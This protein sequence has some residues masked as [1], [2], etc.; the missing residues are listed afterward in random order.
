MKKTVI[1]LLAILVI[2]LTGC[3]QNASEDNRQTPDSEITPSDSL[4]FQ[5]FGPSMTP[6]ISDGEIINLEKTNDFQRGDIVVYTNPYDENQRHVNRIIGLPDE[7]IKLEEGNVVVINNKNSDGFELEEDYLNVKSKGSTYPSIG[8]GAISEFELPNNG[9]LVLG[10]N[11]N[12]STDS[13]SC[14]R[15]AFNGACNNENAQFYIT[16]DN[17]IGKVADIEKFESDIKTPPNLSGIENFGI[18]KDVVNPQIQT[19]LKDILENDSEYELLANYMAENYDYNISNA[20]FITNYIDTS[21]YT[22]ISSGPLYK[23]GSDNKEFAIFVALFPVDDSLK[24]DEEEQN[25]YYIEE[26]TEKSMTMIYVENGEI[27]EFAMKD[28]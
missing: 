4:T 8:E 5:M 26:H 21:Q 12:A 14:F 15:D 1:T 2:S 3:D 9:Y 19:Q 25:Y 11:R 17:I 10:D 20:S 13:R 27:K 16:T 6:T 24:R 28:F 18:P 7:T 22:G 23:S